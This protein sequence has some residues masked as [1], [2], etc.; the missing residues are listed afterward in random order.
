MQSVLTSVL[1][2]VA[3][4]VAVSLALRSMWRD[5]KAGKSCSCGGDC[6]HCKGCH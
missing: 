5:H 6:P 2:I 3:L 1:I 4:A